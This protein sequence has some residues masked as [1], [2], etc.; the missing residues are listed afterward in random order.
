[1]KGVVF[2]YIGTDESGKGDYFGPLVVAAVWADKSTQEELE[3]LGVRD[4]KSLS[5]RRCREL[6]AKIRDLFKSKYEEVEIPP[7]RYNSLYE[8][9]KREGK[10]LNHLLAWGHAR[11]LENLLARYTSQYAVAD[12]FGDEKYILSRLMERGKSLQL[13]QTPKAERYP[14]VAAASILAR[15]RFLSRLQSIAHQVG[16]EL[17]KGAAP[18]VVDAAR[19][20]IDRSGPTA[21]R[22]VAKMHFKTTCAVLGNANE[23]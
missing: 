4:S 6:A 13:E 5:D 20:I 21:L 17:P 2:P 15:D 8:Q 23:D 11:A 22:K 3:E 10:N 18:A 9:F 16:V 14:A 1:M 7:E 19:A 12:R